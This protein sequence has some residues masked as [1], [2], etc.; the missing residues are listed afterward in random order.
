MPTAGNPCVNLCRCLHVATASE[1]PCLQEFL[2]KGVF[3]CP[4]DQLP[5][6]Y[7]KIYLVLELEGQVLGL[8]TCCIHSE[9]GCVW[10][11]PLHHLQGHLNTCSFNIVPSQNCCLATLSQHDLR[12]HLYHNCPKRHLKYEFCGWKFSGKA[13]ER[14]TRACALNRVC[15]V[16]TSVGPA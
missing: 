11:R 6:D 10:S 1:T 12:S 2:S 8:P 13:Y 9:E 7:A 3:K 15:I 16:R 5:L 14:V 4:E